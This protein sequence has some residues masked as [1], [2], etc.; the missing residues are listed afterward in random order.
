MVVEMLRSLSA[1]GKMVIVV[2]KRAAKGMISASERWSWMMIWMV[3]RM[4]STDEKLM[5]QTGM[6]MTE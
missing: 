6:M 4:E 1:M 5:Q 3:T 2:L